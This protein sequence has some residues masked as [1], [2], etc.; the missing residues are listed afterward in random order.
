MLK[1]KEKFEVTV[2]L[3]S[4]SPNSPIQKLMVEKIKLLQKNV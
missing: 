2:C 4:K 3:K 1:L